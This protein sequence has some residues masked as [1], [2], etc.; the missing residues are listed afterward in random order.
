MLHKLA[1]MQ[2]IYKYEG[3]DEGEDV[4]CAPTRPW[5]RTHLKKTAFNMEVPAGQEKA[6]I[7]RWRRGRSVVKGVGRS[8][9][10]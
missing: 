4:N 7:E 8:Q 6:A 10:A 2:E 1:R 5:E 3:K 9:A